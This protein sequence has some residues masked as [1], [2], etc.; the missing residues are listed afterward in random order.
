M[1]LGSIKGYCRVRADDDMMQGGIGLVPAA[2]TLSSRDRMRSVSRIRP[3]LG[4]GTATGKLCLSSPCSTARTLCSLCTAPCRL[5]LLGPAAIPGSGS[6]SGFSAPLHRAT[7]V[8]RYQTEGEQHANAWNLGTAGAK[9]ACK[10]HD[11]HLHAWT[12]NSYMHI[13]RMQFS[14]RWGKGDLG[15]LWNHDWIHSLWSPWRCHMPG[16]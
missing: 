16:G 4:R 9:A 13:E 5:L 15:E 2:L 14:P 11:H 10:R 6:A 12:L 7:S 8:H 3:R 1:Q